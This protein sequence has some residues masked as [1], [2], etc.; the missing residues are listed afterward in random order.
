MLEA[1]HEKKNKQLSTE[2]KP[3]FTGVPD[4]DG[5]DHGFDMVRYA[6][7]AVKKGFTGAGMTKEEAREIW[8]RHKSPL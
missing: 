5:T 3:V 2:D 7:M 8:E 1:H 4:K 6:S